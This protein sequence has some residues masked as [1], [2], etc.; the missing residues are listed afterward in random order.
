MSSL[1]IFNK[2]IRSYRQS[3]ISKNNNTLIVFQ[4]IGL[5]GLFVNGAMPL[6]EAQIGLTL[7]ALRAYRC[8]FA[9]RFEHDF[10]MRGGESRKEAAGF[11][12]DAAGCG[13]WLPIRDA[14]RSVAFSRW[15][16]PTPRLASS[17]PDFPAFYKEA[18]PSHG[19]QA[20]ERR[21]LLG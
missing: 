18:R 21:P 6:P 17:T 1:L 10:P 8:G 5:I 16:A 19:N 15:Q 4:I 3:I 13:P 7:A 20:R 14:V 11:P 9:R 12:T 2:M